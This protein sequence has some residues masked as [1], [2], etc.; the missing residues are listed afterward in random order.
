M[1]KKPNTGKKPYNKE[2]VFKY[3]TIISESVLSGL[4]KEGKGAFNYYTV[5]SVM[6]I[7]P[8]TE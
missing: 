6:F 4:H 2:W 8:N 3:I 5:F 1:T 7:C